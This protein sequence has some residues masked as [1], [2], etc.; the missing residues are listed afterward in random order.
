MI[1]FV[2][3][4]KKNQAPVNADVSFKVQVVLC[5]FYDVNGTTESDLIAWPWSPYIDEINQSANGRVTHDNWWYSQTIPTWFEN[6]V[7]KLLSKYCYA[8]WNH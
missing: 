6:L 4:T 7:K 3:L 8:E 1:S 5:Y 2:V